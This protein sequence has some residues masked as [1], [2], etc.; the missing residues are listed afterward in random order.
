VYTLGLAGRA[1]TCCA[2]TAFRCSVV[3]RTSHVTDPASSS[4][5]PADGLSVRSSA[6]ARGRYSRPG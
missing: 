1:S 5:T 6:C 2:T 3:G 4:F